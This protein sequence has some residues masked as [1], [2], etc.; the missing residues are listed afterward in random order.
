MSRIRSTLRGLFRRGRVEQ[1]LE[2]EIRFH[3]EMEIDRN[4]ER[5]LAPEEARREALKSFGGAEKF[6]DEVRDQSVARFLETVLQDLKYGLRSLW[7]NQAFSAA[8]LIT[9]AL[10]I[11][12]NTAIFSVVNGVLLQSLPYGGGDRL[13][14]LRQDAPS[15]N[16][17]NAGF[18]P[19]EMA[20]YKAQT[21]SFDGLVEYHSM[22]FILL[23]RKE[24]QRVQTAVVSA[25]FFDV[26][27]V[28][29]LLGRTFRKGEDAHGAEAVLVLS[30]AYWMRSFGG[31]PR[32][33]GRVFEM[34]DRPHTVVGV[35]PPIPG[36]PQENDVY[37]PV[38]A[39]P[40]RSR[41]STENNR[42]ARM[43]QVFG[44]LKQDASLSTA[45][46]DLSTIAARL[47]RAYPDAYPKAGF[48][49]APVSLRDEMTRQAR[50]TFLILLGTVGLVLLLACANVANLTL[51][52]LIRREREMAL[53]SAL[54]ADRRRLTRQLLT[55]ST[56]LGLAGGAL[57][58][59]L[60]R[61]GLQL[62]VAF[63]TRFTPR[64]VEIRIDSAVL[65][66]TLAVS[67]ATGIALGLIPV[68]GRRNLAAAIQE[69][70][71]RSTQA[72]G[73][74]R[75]RDLLIVSQVAI[76]FVLL[77]GA[78]LMVR[79]LWNLQR[80]DPGFQTERVLTMRIDLNFSKYLFTARGEAIPNGRDKVIAFHEQLLNRMK[81]EQ[82]VVS[83]AVAGTFPLN[84]G[85][86]G[87][88]NGRF[89]IEGQ[90]PVTPDLLPDADLQQVSQDYFRTIRIPLVRGRS[91]DDRD[92]AG[93]TPV[94]LI[95]Q[96]LARH[97]WKHG[98]PV[99]RRLSLDGGRTW[100]EIVGVVGDVRQYG[101]AAAP[102]D[103][104]YLPLL[105]NPTLSSTFLVR[106]VA[107]PMSM[108]KIVSDT[109]HGIDPD[110]PV[111]HFRTLETVRAESLASPRLTAVLL[112]LFAVLALVITAT[113]I[114]GVLAFSVSQRRHEF[115]IRMAL[116]AAPRTVLHMVLRQG[117]GLVGIGLALGL[118]GG[119]VFTRLLSGLL[120]GVGP[121]DPLTFAAVA[122][123]LASVAVA[124]CAV[125]AR[126][127]THADPMV[128]LRDA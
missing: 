74:H 11:G 12:A 91:F 107:S 48:L 5:G 98:N 65:V 66:F 78:G 21:R 117:M 113:G 123:V 121:T 39:C 44:R 26:L 110:Q 3:L 83:A 16:V 126:R 1:E 55:E 28:K 13:V 87:N 17:E 115:G 42:N 92:R 27:G 30:Y 118:A 111:D 64:A 122:V 50:P 25:E 35:L 68:S 82:G 61:A 109:V 34:N 80:V 29:P 32:V 41:P 101:L 93:K 22:W 15:A 100:V 9:L 77:I 79:T 20:D 76:S 116:G 49:V 99:G 4:L 106:T 40:F 104:I 84:E 120:F 36:Y 89:Q 33:V 2:D 53:R 124:S 38:S 70:G 97:F 94:A 8:A 105:Q 85:G 72:W 127:A 24:P 6:K 102:S 46:T 37:M 54:G 56:V 95:N 112:L 69:S 51:A 58:L 103:Q 59:L 19:L 90:P 73:K 45:R 88:F 14:R 81:G 86:P 7:K 67:I 10:G 75:L 18:S 96:T 31:D 63:A 57:G 71:E 128:A 47:T 62:L 23:G 119:V 52:R 108:S 43:L 60:A 125:P 114:A